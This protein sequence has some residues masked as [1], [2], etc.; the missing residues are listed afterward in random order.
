MAHTASLLN[1]KSEFDSF[2]F[3]PVGED[4]RGTVVSVLTAFARLDF[5]PWQ[6]AADLARLPKE[7]AK[8]RLVAVLATL[9]G[10]ASSHAEPSAVAARLIQLLPAPQAAIAPRAP[11]LGAGQPANF[12]SPRYILSIVLFVALGFGS[13]FFM[14]SQQ[15]PPTKG[16]PAQSADTTDTRSPAGGRVVSVAA[17]GVAAAGIESGS[18]T[19]RDLIDLHGEASQTS[20]DEATLAARPTPEITPARKPLFGK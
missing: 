12:R 15:P 20:G 19:R 10:M 4:K 9:P 18:G 6:Q 17:T 13:Q 14:A 11:W 3:A 2:L 1:S 5:D 7:A 8:T 16:A